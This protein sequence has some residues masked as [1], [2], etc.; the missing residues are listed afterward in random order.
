MGCVGC[1]VSVI[2]V[3]DCFGFGGCARLIMAVVVAVNAV[4]SDM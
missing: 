2:D 1:C 4:S 3:G